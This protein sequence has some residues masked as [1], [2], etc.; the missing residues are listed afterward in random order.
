MR[1][2]RPATR[3]GPSLFNAYYEKNAHTKLDKEILRRTVS[4]FVWKKT[5]EEFI[6]TR[7]PFR[8]LAAPQGQASANRA[9]H[10]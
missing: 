6:V 1:A 4:N 5:I 10:R 2:Q 7:Y 8:P 9:L 3:F